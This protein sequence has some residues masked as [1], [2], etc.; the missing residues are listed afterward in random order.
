MTHKI[1]FSVCGE[2][3]GH[4]SRDIAIA[5]SLSA[6]GCEIL[7]GGYGYVLSRLGKSFRSVKIQ[8][9]IEMV[10]KGGAF[11]LK[12]TILKS[13]NT[14]FQFSNIISEEKKIM[15]EFNATCV[16]ADGRTAAV[17]A[18]FSLGIPCVIISNQTSLEPFFKESSFFIR[19]LGIPVEMTLKTITA[20]A[21]ITIIPDFMPPD[22]VCLKTLSQSP[23]IMKKQIFVGPVVSIDADPGDPVDIDTPFILTLLGGHSYRRPIFDNIL[24][25]A[26]RFPDINFLLFTKFKSES[27]PENVRILEFVDDISSYMKSAQ[28]IITQAGHSTAME[29]LTLGKPSLIIPD[30][31]QIEQESNAQRMKE[32]GVCETIQYSSLGTDLLSGKI[33]A[34]LSDKRFREKAMHYSEKARMMDGSIKAS[35]LI[36]ELSGR[37]QCY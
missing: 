17:L 19:F 9:E 27:Y 12:A 1:Y 2:G 37:I 23:Q 6:N 36:M 15:E 18:A 26:N 33:N 13:R 35:G 8:R 14:A 21:E 3:Y 10:G 7:M 32:L 16:V 29:I 25:I 28:A 11:D 31:G 4:S 22:T 30:E 34:L 5:K 24:K 20:L